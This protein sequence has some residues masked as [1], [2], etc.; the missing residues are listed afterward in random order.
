[1]PAASGQVLD[2][3]RHQDAAQ[4]QRG[5]GHHTGSPWKPRAIGNEVKNQPCRWLTSWMSRRRPP[6]WGH[7][8][9]RR[10]PAGVRNPCPAAWRPPRP[11][12]RRPAVRPP[13]GPRPT[14]VAWAPAPPGARSP[15]RSP[16]HLSAGASR[17]SVAHAVPLSHRLGER[18]A[19]AAVVDRHATVPT[20]PAGVGHGAR[21]GT[22]RRCQVRPSSR[23]V[24]AASASR[25]PS[26]WPSG[27]G[28]SSPPCATWPS[29]SGSTGRS[30]RPAPRR[31]STSS[32][33][34]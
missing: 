8:E 33:W 16:G 25:R 4:R 6:R 14:P 20:G 34:T 15:P 7:R 9:G 13:R 29:A 1:M 30:P 5:R 2:E 19:C 21:T 28:G 22:I 24:R 17:A 18:R 11:G 27:A 10:A 12:T 32:G 31:R 26:R 23:V 3:Q